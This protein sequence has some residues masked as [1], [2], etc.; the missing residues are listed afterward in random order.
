VLY[1]SCRTLA[2]DQ[3]LLD[4]K[5]IAIAANKSVASRRVPAQR[6]WRHYLLRSEH[7]KL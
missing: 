3:A 2:A 7:Y 1:N 6:Y 5:Q 4:I